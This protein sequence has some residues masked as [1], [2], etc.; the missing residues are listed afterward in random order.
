MGY[1]TIVQN[2]FQI[3]NEDTKYVFISAVQSNMSAA[4]L[5][6][7]WWYELIYNIPIELSSS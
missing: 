3:P 7:H 6:N 5:D 1:R 2:F 4:V